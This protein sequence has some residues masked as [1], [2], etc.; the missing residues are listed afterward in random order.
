MLFFKTTP[1]R[2]YLNGID[3]VMAALNNLNKKHTT[4]G[5]HSQL[6][7]VLKGL[8][9]KKWLAHRLEEYL[10]NCRFLKG[11][12]KRAWHL[13]PYW[14]PEPANFDSKNLRF[15]NISSNNR[16]KLDSTI[17][18]CA[19]TPF[20][21]DRTV[22]SFDL[23]HFN[24]RSYVIMRFDHKM[25]D[26]RGAESLLE[27]ILDHNTFQTKLLLPVQ[28]A[29]LDSWKSRFLSGQCINRFLRSIYNSK[30]EV[31]SL[32]HPEKSKFLHTFFVN[33][34]SEDKSLLIDK[35]SFNKAGYLMNGIYSLSCAA[36]A[37]DLL[38]QKHK[39]NSSMLIPINVDVR[40]TKFDNLKI[41]FNNVSFMLFDTQQGLSISEHIKSLKNQFIDQVKNKIPFHFINASL[42]MR[43]MPLKLL[44]SFMEFRMEKNRCS[45]SFSYISEQAFFLKHVQ[46]LEVINL[47]HMPL[48]PVSPGIG[49]FFTK[50]NNRLNMIIS[51]F[52]NKLNKQD[53]NFL[54][55]KIISGLIN[56]QV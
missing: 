52:D 11:K 32:C 46:N 45:F 40:G 49:V 38:F 15:F 53:G 50:F 10:S 18:T 25:F 55:E 19:K 51:S 41:F 56:E 35:N 48:V 9:D 2:Y 26:A 39:Q 1:D 28:K 54:K 6:V 21:N 27:R 36:K 8:L 42:L 31:A 7:L 24:S 3:W 33:N 12:T 47:F 20:E 16:E 37:F 23:I 4:I 22:L 34:F 14:K 44:S 29:Q 43:I 30:K 13:A 17:Q 5:N